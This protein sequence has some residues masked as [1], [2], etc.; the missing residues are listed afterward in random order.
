M[1]VVSETQQLNAVAVVKSEVW[2]VLQVQ[3]YFLLIFSSRRS[4]FR[5]E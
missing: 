4:F 2:L 5:Q 3:L 1:A